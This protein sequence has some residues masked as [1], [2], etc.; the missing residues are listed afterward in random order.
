[1]KSN[2]T[3]S[4]VIFMLKTIGVFC[5][6]IRHIDWKHSDRYICAMIKISNK[7]DKIFRK[8]YGT[9]SYD[10]KECEGMEMYL[11]TKMTDLMIR[12]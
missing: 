11:I 9:N 2:K 6:T 1:M 10:D 8:N 3:L 7:I 4:K 5:R 12:L